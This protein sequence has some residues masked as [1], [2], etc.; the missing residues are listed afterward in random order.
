MAPLDRKR[1]A[2]AP[3]DNQPPAKRS[4]S[5][6]N[7]DTS[8]N[9]IRRTATGVVIPL[10][11]AINYNTEEDDFVEAHETQD[12]LADG[13]ADGAESMGG[14]DGDATSSSSR[15]VEE[16]DDDLFKSTFGKAASQPSL[17]EDYD[18]DDD[19]DDS[20]G[21]STKS[22]AKAKGKLPVTDYD[23]VKA[24][25]TDT[26]KRSPAASTPPPGSHKV[27]AEAS[28]SPSSF[29]NYDNTT[30]HSTATPAPPPVKKEINPDKDMSW[31]L[32][33]HKRFHDKAV[34]LIPRLELAA[35]R[36]WIGVLHVDRKPQNAREEKHFT[37]MKGNCL[38]TVETIWH[39]CRAKMMDDEFVLLLGGVERVDLT[40]RC[41]ELD[42]FNDK[43]IIFQAVKE[44]DPA[45]KGRE[46]S[47]GIIPPLPQD[48][49]KVIEI[50]D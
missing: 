50:L 8:M 48:P 15:D 5:S 46:I 18:D 14:D 12:D 19:S 20:R 23:F 13:V 38:I 24:E 35:H 43:K 40:D 25:H 31:P 33:T 2:A 37:W 11:Q 39:E 22:S 27:K 9:L 42:Y 7:F 17:H 29:A 3:A 44:T 28:K 32:R 30:R 47:E 45:A 10:A 6:L 41:E 16:D 36:Y 49:T 1:Q 21:V 34:Q 26:C 4:H